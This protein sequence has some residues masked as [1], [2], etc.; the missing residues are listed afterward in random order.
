[1]RKSEK[2]KYLILFSV[3]IVLLVRIT[4]LR[5]KITILKARRKLKKYITLSENAKDSQESAAAF[6]T[7]GNIFLFELEDFNSAM[8]YFQKV[9]DS[10]QKNYLEDSALFNLGLCLK[11]I[12]KREKAKEIFLKVV[13]SFPETARAKDTEL[14]ITRL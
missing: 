8:D 2:L 7:I 11:K 4:W 10:D 12:G 5:K 9:V 1:M 13:E 3:I 6:Y 14:E